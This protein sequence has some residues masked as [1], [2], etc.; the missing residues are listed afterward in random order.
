MRIGQHDRAN[1]EVSAKPQVAGGPDHQQR[2]IV[3]QPF[4]MGTLEHELVHA[5]MGPVWDPLPAVLVEGLC[6]ALADNLTAFLDGF[7]GAHQV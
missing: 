3:G 2:A 4:L 1:G 6:D 5:W 7:S